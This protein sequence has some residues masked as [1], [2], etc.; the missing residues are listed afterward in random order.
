M[1]VQSFA[2][3]YLVMAI[4]FVVAVATE[5]FVDDVMR[6]STVFG[7]LA[8]STLISGLTTTIVTEKL[9]AQILQ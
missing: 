9:N 8:I 4:L 5:A 3:L 7:F 1:R 2:T 6:P